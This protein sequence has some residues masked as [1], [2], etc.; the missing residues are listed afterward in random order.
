MK[1]NFAGWCGLAATMPVVLMSQS[2]LAQM[3]DFTGHKVVSID[4]RSAADLAVLGA[5]SDGMWG[6]TSKRGA[7]EYHFSPEKY[8]A[9]VQHAEA[10]GV[11]YRVVIEDIEAV[12]RQERA[13]IARRNMQRDLNWFNN[14]RTLA[15]INA[16]L[17]ADVAQWPTLA[18]TF[19]VGT[20]LE[21]RVTRGILISAPDQPGN[22]RANRP[23][24]IIHGG[25]HAREWIS[26]MTTMW[27]AEQMLEQYALGGRA[28][29]AL[30]RVDLMV[31]PVMNPDG[32]SFTWTNNRLWRKNRRANSNGT[33]GVDL[34]R[35]WG[36]QWGGEGASTDPGNDT[37]R[38]PSAF[39]E[40]ETQYMRDFITA[41][42]RLKG[43]IDFHSYS[44]L[45]LSPWGYTATLPPDAATFDALNARMV[46]SIRAVH[47]LTYTAG[48][49][50]TTIYPA[51]GGSGDWT[52]GVRNILGYGWEL[53]DT[54]QFG[55][56]LP[57]DQIVPTGQENFPAVLDMM[58]WVG[59]PVNIAVTQ[60]PTTVISG[61][62]ATVSARVLR[63]YSAVDPASVRLWWRVG[64][65]GAFASVVMSESGGEF[66]S[67]ISASNCGQTIQYYITAADTGGQMV[68]APDGAP[69][70]VFTATAVPAPLWTESFEVAGTWTYGVAG[71]TAT[72]GRWER[73]IPQ[74]TAA[75]PGADVTP[76]S[77]QLCAVTDGR[78][79][80]A[81]G[82]YDIDGGTTTLLSPRFDARPLA[83]GSASDVW[84][85]YSRWYS[86]DRGS[87]PNA[88]SM[89]VEISNNDGSTWVLLELVTENANAWVQKDWRISD[90]VAPTQNMR[91]RFVAR[92]LGSGSVVEAA[93]D[94]VKVYVT[95]C[96]C[97]ADF[98]AD[99]TLDFFDY[100]DFVAAFSSTGAAADF[101]ADTVIDFF[102][103]LD[104]V[105][106]FSSGC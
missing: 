104:F 84:L 24:V 47:G 89:P 31:I 33:F 20:S 92:D 13:D 30:N 97:A 80:T 9:F 67:S 7:N 15:E 100:L 26:P 14:Y 69:S 56:E 85:R 58:E 6:C 82:T 21:G 22:P 29:A 75:Q 11:T 39:S 57:A 51:S 52:Y 41:N 99:G 73:A 76:G 91:L 77:G 32:Y 10:N 18:S 64:T 4:V 23:Q 50:Y 16:K 86:N 81:V 42:T 8:A 90:F 34:N 88:D 43:H 60:Q 87:A 74:A 59:S 2:S 66:S 36:Y 101:N 68:A 94:E 46:A 27:V 102:D 35:N 54:G 38:G 95:S 49:I 19:T 62:T 83:G 78:P 53:R 105:A 65:S 25:Q 45:I 55:F 61:S 71:D 103:Y 5:L 17:D 79:G 70:A 63:G 40:P 37:Y 12:F 93:V 98:N 28:A 72:A 3:A 1:M 106:A 48:P 96:P 44:Q